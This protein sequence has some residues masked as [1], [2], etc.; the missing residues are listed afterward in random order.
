MS[1]VTLA[2][3]SALDVAKTV[4][5]MAGD[6]RSRASDLEQFAF[7]IEEMVKNGTFINNT[8]VSNVT[9]VGTS[10]LMM[11]NNLGSLQSALYSATAAVQ[12]QADGR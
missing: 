2:Q 11:N 8:F 5:G 6:L 9:R 12:Y 1:D 4:R 10:A 3:D 7:L